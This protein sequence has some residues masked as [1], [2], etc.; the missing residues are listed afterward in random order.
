MQVDL[1]PPPLCPFSPADWLPDGL[2]STTVFKTYGVPGG[3]A[4]LPLLAPLWCPVPCLAPP[5]AVSVLEWDEQ[6]QG[7][8]MRSVCL[9]ATLQ[10]VKRVE[11]QVITVAARPKPKARRKKA[12]PGAGHAGSV[13]RPGTTQRSVSPQT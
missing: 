7:L 10:R 6:H 13:T 2:P 11:V 3:P 5:P 8:V 9:A 12:V 4:T 1:V